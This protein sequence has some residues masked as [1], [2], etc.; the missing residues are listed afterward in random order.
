MSN[1]FNI[2]NF[3]IGKKRTFI[4]AEIGVNH[5]GNLPF[6]K[7]LINAAKKSGADAAKL[8]IINPEESYAKNTKSYKIFKKNILN[9]KELKQLRDYAKSKKILLFATPGDFSS[10]NVVRK[11]KFPAIKISSGLM[12]NIPLI[13]DCAKTRLPIII[14]TGFAKLE[15]IQEALANITKFH[16]KVAV[17]KCTSLYPAPKSTLNLNSIKTFKKKL[18]TIIGYSDHSLGE[19]SCLIAVS[20][21]AKVIEKHFTL[22]KKLA[23]A[24]H[25]ISMTPKEFSIMV[26]KIREI[27]ESL[28]GEDTFPTQ[29]ELMIRNLYRRTIVSS[30]IIKKGKKIEKKDLLLQRSNLSGKKLHPR[31]FFKLIGKKSK[32]TILPNKLIK[33]NDFF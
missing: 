29:K 30:K 15:E 18:K 33:K 3:V 6:A 19:L 8:Q 11:L 7:K 4:I 28:G 20:L 17:L 1:F 21:G 14:S 27:E 5:N 9:L 16:K 12:N 26:N 22:N 13:I 24:D 10:L 31:D 25:K 23:G 32:R 2:K